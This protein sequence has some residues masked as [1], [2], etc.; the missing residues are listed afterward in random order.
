MMVYAKV[1][2]VSTWPRSLGEKKNVSNST[3]GQDR[4]SLA[5]SSMPVD[6]DRY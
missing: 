4:M 5:R 1:G 3:L 2:Q 6:Q